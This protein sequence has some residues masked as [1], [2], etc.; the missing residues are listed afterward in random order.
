MIPQSRLDLEPKR[1]TEGI[2]FSLFDATDL[3]RAGVGGIDSGLRRVAFGIPAEIFVF[4][5]AADS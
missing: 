2:L 4:L 3:F 5:P 1:F